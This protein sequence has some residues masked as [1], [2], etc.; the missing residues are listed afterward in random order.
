MKV[1]RHW[2][3]LSAG[4]RPHGREK[5]PKGRRGFHRAVG[6]ADCGRLRLRPLRIEILP[7]AHE[8]VHH[9]I[10][11]ARVPTPAAPAAVLLFVRKP[12]SALPEAPP[13][14]DVLHAPPRQLGAVVATTAMGPN[15]ME[16][17]AGTALRVRAGTVLTFQMYYTAHGHEMRDRT[18]VGF[19][20]VKEPLKEEVLVGSFINGTFTLP[21]GAKDIAVPAELEPTVPVRIWVLLPHTHL[22]GTRWQYTLERP[23]GSSTVILDVPH[24]DFNWQTYY[25]FSTPLEVPAGGKIVSTAWYDNSAS[26]RN[27]PDPTKAVR[28]G[29]QTWR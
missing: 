9:V 28:W 2:R 14:V 23:D 15:V 20:F 11:Y 13:R 24:Y 26:N 3:I 4:G 16:F 21:A 7:G 8:V 10:V 29:E 22:R 17:S 27:N 6:Y 25:L 12:Q 5:S 18:S 1:Q 19:R